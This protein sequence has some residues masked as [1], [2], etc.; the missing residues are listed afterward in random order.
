MSDLSLMERIRRGIA[1]GKSGGGFPML[2]LAIVVLVVIGMALR[3]F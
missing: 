1:R 3:P 2:V